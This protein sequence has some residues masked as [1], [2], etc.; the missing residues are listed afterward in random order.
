MKYWR[1]DVISTRGREVDYTVGAR[2]SARV[3]VVG[4]KF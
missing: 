2:R 4:L 1:R 3:D